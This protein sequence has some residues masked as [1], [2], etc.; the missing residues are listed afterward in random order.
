MSRPPIEPAVGEAYYRQAELHRLRGETA[1][2]E[3]AYREASTWGRR[4]DPGL[5]LLRLASGD[6]PAAAA[7]I[8][9]A[10]DEADE[11]SRMR[12]LEPYVEITLRRHDQV[13]ART[14]ADELAGRAVRFSA[15]LPRAIAAR[16][17]GRVLLAEGDPRA[18]LA[19]LRS[20]AELWLQLDAPYELARVRVQL[21]L[22]CLA[23]GDSD[24]ADLELSAARAVFTAL[25]AVADL[26]DVEAA[27]GRD[28]PWRTA[29]LSRRELEVLRRV[30]TG[31]TNRD[32]ATELGISERTVDR[33]VSNVFT[34]L[35]VSSR[36]AA[37]AY[38]YEHRLV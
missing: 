8:Q 2:A 11:F 14:A 16:A 33:H 23:I 28:G 7:S 9:R 38:A 30:A 22:A 19:S 37:T 26:A 10:L 5:A 17:V 13:A 3:L 18:A 25:G 31:R 29:G 12:L 6:G 1:E 21:G 24:G 35:D 20:S 4:P 34:K 27:S 36:A 32:I 15:L